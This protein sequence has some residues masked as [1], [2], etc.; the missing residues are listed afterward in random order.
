[1]KLHNS[2]E[3]GLIEL[4]VFFIYGDE[5]YNPFVITLRINFLVKE[6]FFKRKNTNVLGIK[7]I[8]KLHLE[9]LTN[10]SV[11]KDIERMSNNLDN[12]YK[13]GIK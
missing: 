5:N 4:P 6:D 7:K 1:M 9:Y 10:Q 13:N 2:S 8:L 3:G 12:E 11:N